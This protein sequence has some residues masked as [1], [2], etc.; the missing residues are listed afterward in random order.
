MDMISSI[1]GCTVTTT[2]VVLGKFGAAYLL[3]L[4]WQTVKPGGRSP[5]QVRDLAKDSPRKLFTMGFLTNL[6]NPKVGLFYV[7]FLPQFIAPGEDVLTLSV[8]MEV[9]SPSVTV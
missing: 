6:L 8:L 4:A 5:F 7:T 9:V 1:C 2:E 3:Y